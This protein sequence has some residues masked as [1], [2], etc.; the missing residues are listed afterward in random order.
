RPTS[1]RPVWASPPY[2]RR[3]LRSLT[4]F[5]PR[6]VF[7]SVRCR[8]GR[9]AIAGRSL[10]NVVAGQSLATT[11]FQGMK[12]LKLFLL[13]FSLTTSFAQT[14]PTVTTS[15]AKVQHSGHVDLRGTGFTPK[16]NVF[17]HLR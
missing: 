16:A 11:L 15:P 10:Q 7:G 8:S 4:R 3:Y 13:A 5:S 12:I 6:R 9:R 1:L 17:S 2:H 14:K